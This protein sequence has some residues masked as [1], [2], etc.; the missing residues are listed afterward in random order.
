[1]VS[2]VLQ[3]AKM[4]LGT[5]IASREVFLQKCHSGNTSS[6]Q[7]FGLGNDTECTNVPF[8]QL[9]AALPPHGML[10]T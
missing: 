2:A 3:M 9:I 5:H 7:V 10:Q 8:K 4:Q 6:E 1:M